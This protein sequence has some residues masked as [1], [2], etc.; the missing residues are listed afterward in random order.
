MQINVAFCSFQ[1][2]GIPYIG[3]TW[4]FPPFHM[5]GPT[6]CVMEKTCICMMYFPH[7]NNS[8][9]QQEDHHKACLVVP[10]YMISLNFA[11]GIFNI[12][13]L[14]QVQMAI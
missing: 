2:G 4:R 3:C 1:R 9:L 10:G 7:F 8:L 12:C 11:L 13:T 5:W 6:P 14:D